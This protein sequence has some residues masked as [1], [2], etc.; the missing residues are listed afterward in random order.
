MSSSRTELRARRRE[1]HRLGIAGNA[2]TSQGT[3]TQRWLTSRANSRSASDGASQPNRGR[4]YRSLFVSS[5]GFGAL[6]GASGGVAGGAASSGRSLVVGFG[7]DFSEE[8][9]FQDGEPVTLD[10]ES[11]LIVLPG[12]SAFAVG[13][14][15]GV[16]DQALVDPVRDSSFQGPDCFFG[17]LAFG[18][19]AVVVVAAFAGVAE[20]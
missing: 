1:V 11:C 17:G 10:T 20:L 18:A 13:G 4:P 8:P 16:G 15:A 14:G 9:A 5:G 19:F 3:T 6:L 12:L 7:S 2:P